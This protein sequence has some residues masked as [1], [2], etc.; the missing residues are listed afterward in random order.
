[1]PCLNKGNT[2]ASIHYR[3]A[4][5]L[6]RMLSLLRDS[7]RYDFDK[8]KFVLLHKTTITVTIETDR[9]ISPVGNAEDRAIDKAIRPRRLTDY[10]GQP[11]VREQKLALNRQES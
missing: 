2:L 4:E 11:Q 5:K 9:L 7:I 1:L 10:T 3:Y 6:L 8:L